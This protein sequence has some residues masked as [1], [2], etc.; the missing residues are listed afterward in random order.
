MVGVRYARVFASWAARRAV[1]RS[2]RHRPTITSTGASTRLLFTGRIRLRTRCRRRRDAMD[3]RA[4]TRPSSRLRASCR[5][6]RPRWSSTSRRSDGSTRARRP[7]WRTPR[8]TRH[9]ATGVS[10]GSVGAGTGTTVGKVAGP[11]WCMKGGFGC[12]IESTASNDL[13]VGAMVV[14][15]A[16]GDVR[17]AHGEIIA[18][19]RRPSGGFAD[20]PR[21]LASRRHSL[22][23][24]VRRP[25]RAEHDA[26]R[27][28]RERSALAEYV[29][30]ARARGQ[31]RAVPAHHAERV[32]VRRRHRVR[33]VA[34]GRR[35][36]ARRSR[37]SSNRS[38]SWRWKMPSSAPCAARAAAREFP[39][40][41]THMPES[42]GRAAGDAILYC[43]IIRAPV[44]PMHGEP[45]IS[46]A[47][48]SQQLAGHRVDA[49]A[50]DGEWVRVR[51]DGRL[52]GMD[53]RRLSRPGAG[54]HRSPK[55][56]HHAHLARLLDEDGIGREP[57]ASASRV[58]RPG[59]DAHIGRR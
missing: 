52:R 20:T 28:R 44:A 15:N 35:G 54:H 49:L 5:S 3:G 7:R 58:S 57:R 1:A 8:P 26:R 39:V 34:D 14:V 23:E 16:F 24:Q 55:P 40:S 50:E 47:M 51:G 42:P 30:A 46:S 18:G 36:R 27:R 19:A 56:S 59:R 43:A 45:R 37:S 31:R 29:D 25:R 22:A 48:I 33:A 6:C 13:S 17:D 32:V 38:P 9:A 21:V 4:R 10:E 2:R 11:A 12:A 41:P 53:S